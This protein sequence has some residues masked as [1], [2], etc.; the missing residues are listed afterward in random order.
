ME[1][2]TTL[3]TE[4]PGGET[5]ELIRMVEECVRTMRRSR[6]EEQLNALKEKLAQAQGAE[7]A[8]ILREI[9]QLTNELKEMKNRG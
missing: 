9:L 1:A 3:P 6:A 7:Q 5:D 4:R 8:E 2:A